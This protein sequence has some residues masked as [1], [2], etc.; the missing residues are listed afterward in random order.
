MLLREDAVEEGLQG[1][2]VIYIAYILVYGV[3]D[4]KHVR[5]FMLKQSCCDDSGILGWSFDPFHGNRSD[6]SPKRE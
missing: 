3:Q 4:G 5:S 1:S 6:L 2:S